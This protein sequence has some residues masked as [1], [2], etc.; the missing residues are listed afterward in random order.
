MPHIL[1]DIGNSAAQPTAG[2]RLLRL[3]LEDEAQERPRHSVG[4]ET[5]SQLGSVHAPESRRVLA[6]L[7]CAST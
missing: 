4:C 5:R 1:P 6:P 3:D 2:R 7:L